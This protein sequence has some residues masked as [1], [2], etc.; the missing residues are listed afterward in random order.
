MLGE[1]PVLYMF[2]LASQK[3]K[4]EN[5]TSDFHPTYPQLGVLVSNQSVILSVLKENKLSLRPV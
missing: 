5:A 1:L 4:I 3:V 2:C